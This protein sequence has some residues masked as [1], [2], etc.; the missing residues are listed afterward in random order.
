[1]DVAAPNIDLASPRLTIDDVDLHQVVVPCDRESDTLMIHSFGRGRPGVSV[2]VDDDLHLRLDRDRTRVLGMQIEG[3]VSRVSHER[4]E[5]LD[6][7]DSADLRGISLEQLA[8]RR[9]EVGN[10]RRT[11]AVIGDPIG[12]LPSSGHIAKAS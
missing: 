2:A 7:L 10:E 9:R 12:R 5:L 4:S 6:L 8:R 3:F 11:Q 1:M